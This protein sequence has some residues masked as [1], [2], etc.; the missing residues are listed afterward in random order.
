MVRRLFLGLAS[1]AAL[2]LPISTAVAQPTSSIPGLHLSFTQPTGTVSSTA[3]IDIFL[4]LSLDPNAAAFTFDGSSPSTNFGVPDLVLPTTGTYNI[5]GQQ[6]NG[7]FDPNSPNEYTSASTTYSLECSGSFFTGCGGSPYDFNFSFC[8]DPTVGC[9]LGLSSFTLQPGNSFEF[10]FGTL[11]PTGG[12]A[13]PGTYNL[14]NT[15]AI[16]SVAGTGFEAD[17]NGNEILDANGNPIPIP[18]QDS[19]GNT[20]FFSGDVNIA[21]TCENGATNPQC[22]FTR[23]VVDTTATPEPATLTLFGLGLVAIGG[24]RRRRRTA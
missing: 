21:D 15:A 20:V 14:F 5:N 18:T 4:T 2:S 17:Q 23:T 12:A 11:T 24:A 16:I 22:N 7:I 3:P 10:L 9:F 1:V 8:T 6:E 19:N 13:P